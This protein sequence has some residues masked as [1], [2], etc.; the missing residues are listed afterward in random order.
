MKWVKSCLNCA[1][2]MIV[3][4]DKEIVL[5]QSINEEVTEPYDDAMYCGAYEPKQESE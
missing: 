2:G 4:A 1:Y 3:D 5:C